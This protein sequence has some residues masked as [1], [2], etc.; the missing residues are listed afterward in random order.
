MSHNEDKES[1]NNNRMKFIF[2]SLTTYKL[3]LIAWIIIGIGFIVGIIINFI[4]EEWSS[5]MEAIPFF[6]PFLIA[7]SLEVGGV[8]AILQYTKNS[9]FQYEINDKFIKAS[10]PFIPSSKGNSIQLM[11]N[12]VQAMKISRLNRSR[13]MSIRAS[14][15]LK[16]GSKVVF[17]IPKEM[18]FELRKRYKKSRKKSF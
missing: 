12:Q 14:F 16:D 8:W 18:E 17:L 6:I 1:N 3:G 15:K 2:N 5:I 10:K 4:L 7:I 9:Y 11:F 13:D